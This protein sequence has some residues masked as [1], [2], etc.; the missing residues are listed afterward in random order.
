M[1]VLKIKNLES[2][3]ENTV[4][5]SSFNLDISHHEV[6]AIHANTNVRTVLKKMLM[7]LV[8]IS[9][10][11]IIVNE[12]N[13]RDAKREVLVQTGFFSLDD[14]LYERLSVKENFSFYQK[15]YDSQV[16][17][18]DAIN[19]VQLEG[20]KNTRLSKLS[21]SEKM[22]VHFGRLLLQNSLFYFFEE[23][24]QNADLET[25]RVLIKFIRELK[26]NG[27]TVLVLTSNL[28]S[29]LAVT[30]KVYRLNEDG[31]LALDIKQ[32][33]DTDNEEVPHLPD[34][35]YQLNEDEII[36]QPVRF[37]KIPTK[38][39]DKII[40]FDPTE[41][42]YIESNDGQSNIFIKGEM[43]PSVF[44]MTE[45][46]KRLHPYGFFRCHR[47]YIVNLQKVREVVTWTRNSF[48]LVLGDTKKSSIPL[49]KTKM[50]ELK[51]MLG[52]K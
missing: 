35:P 9:V 31:L 49:S 48:T 42:D 18:G 6:V 51:E 16:S 45:L 46:E 15:L 40:L 38:V 22:R 37:E 36:V 1:S 5:F 10:G 50:T 20:K 41:I 34:E 11:D 21:Y 3:Y 2:Q 19:F 28:E 43:F 25:K 32:E 26:Q 12:K 24:D 47:S 52:L 17:V 7:G 33:T 30:E 44:T 29:A 39:N 8:P 14:G 4:V 13:I 23:P 27:K